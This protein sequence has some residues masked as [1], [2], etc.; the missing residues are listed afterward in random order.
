M[1]NTIR[2][3]ILLAFSALAAITGFLGLYAVS[4]VVESR[5][6]VVHTY[7]KPLMSIS[8]ARLAVSSFTSMQ[9]ALPQ[10]Q[11]SADDDRRAMLDARLHEPYPELEPDLAVAHDLASYSR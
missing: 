9:V 11:L 8:Y 1:A 4:S 7:D 2:G 3:K 6:L 5:R 10:R